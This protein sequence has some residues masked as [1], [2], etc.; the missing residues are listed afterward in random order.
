MNRA[1]CG[2]VLLLVFGV[3]PLR[4]Q[5][6]APSIAFESLEQDLG[7]VMQGDPAKYVFKFRNS[8]TG[9]LKIVDVAAGCGCT[10]TLL[11]AKQVK[12]GADGEIGVT[13][14]TNGITGPI[15]K[16][17]TVT[18]NDPRHPKVNLVIAAVVEPEIALSESAI[19]FGNVPLYQ[20][21][22]KEI[23]LTIPADK[24]IKIVSTQS[25]DDN[26]G[27]N[28]SPVPQTNGKKIKVEVTHKA[29]AKRGYFFGTVVIKT[30]S[31][32]TPEI[33]LGLR[34]TVDL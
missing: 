34:G 32:R 6:G 16:A 11:S 22:T 20:E 14:N 26:I 4:A 7:K 5:A 8:G 27:V 30:T 28:F 33:T 12:P 31:R 23:I 9:T 29:N 17:V 21:V 10:T 3:T 18:S 13:V 25:G 19:F 15:R 2:A 1:F 24:A